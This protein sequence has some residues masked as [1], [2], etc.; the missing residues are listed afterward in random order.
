MRLQRWM[1][2]LI[3]Q[4]KR[5]FGSILPLFSLLWVGGLAVAILTLWVFIELADEVLH[6][7][8]EAIDTSILLMVKDW[9]TP[10]LTPIMHGFSLVGGTVFVTSLCLL[11]G[12]WC[13]RKQHWSTLKAFAVVAIGGTL[14]NLLMKQVFTRDRPDIASLVQGNPRTS[15]FPSGHAMM[16]LIVYGFIAYLLATRYSRWR[17]LIIG[18]LLVLVLG[19]GLSRV[20]LGIHW[21]TDV[22]AGYTAGLTWLFACVLSWEVRLQYKR[23]HSAKVNSNS[24]Q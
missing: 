6:K 23:L 15:S 2:S 24:N 22:V 21:A 18:V 10:W 1:H 17:W 14:L 3:H 7:Q 8:T 9:R 20:Y 13:W 4:W 12:I 11:V 5:Q 16:S 19:I